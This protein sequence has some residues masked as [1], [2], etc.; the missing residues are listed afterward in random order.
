MPE[1]RWHNSSWFDPENLRLVVGPAWF[2][3][4]PPGFYA[5]LDLGHN[6]LLAVAKNAWYV[7]RQMPNP[8]NLIH[9]SH[10]SLCAT[11]PNTQ[12]KARRVIFED[13]SFLHLVNHER[14]LYYT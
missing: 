14:L 9:L 1:L 13:C 5:M 10:L 11:G 6:L 4:L 7:L 12:G 3:G 8:S 2:V